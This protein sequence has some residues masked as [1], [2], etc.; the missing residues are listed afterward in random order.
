[1]VNLIEKAQLMDEPAMH[2]TLV[3]MAHEIVEKNAET[4]RICLI[5][6]HRRGIPLA[7][8]LAE[9]IRKF[10]D[11]QTDVGS[12]DITLYRDDLTCIAPDPSVNN[13]KVDFSVDG[14]TVILV[15]DV[16]YTGRTIRAAMDAL[17]KLGRPAKIQLAVL[18]DRGQRELP[19]R[20][21]YVGKNVPTSKKELISVCV[22][23]YDGKTG[24]YVCEPKE[25]I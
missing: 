25:E 11:L 24:V 5:G 18:I 9:N 2:R 16:I 22:G 13:T 19:I 20:G 3:R 8:E 14:E 23:E 17:I 7:K 10:S 15:D 21:D 6:I 1:M 12:V 4:D